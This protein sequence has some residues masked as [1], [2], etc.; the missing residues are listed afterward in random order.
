MNDHSDKAVAEAS[1]LGVLRSTNLRRRFDLENHVYH[2]I[3]VS[4]DR[5][6]IFLDTACARAVIEAIDLVR[7]DR[8]ALILAYALMPDH[9]HLLVAPLPGVTLSDV[10]RAIKGPSARQINLLRGSLG[11]IWQQSFHDRVIRDEAHLRATIAYIHENP[12]AEGLASVP[13]EYE[14]SSAFRGARSDL[15]AYSGA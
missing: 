4:R 13:H 1:S 3:S 11:S 5:R 14:F 9:L 6:P 15:E 2:T 7:R 10:M 8:K 12:I